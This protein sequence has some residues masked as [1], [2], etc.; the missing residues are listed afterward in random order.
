MNTETILAILKNL[1]TRDKNKCIQAIQKLYRDKTSK[2]ET[3]NDELNE[4]LSKHG[5]LIEE[6]YEIIH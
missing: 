2:V 3:K 4:W 5:F 6:E 1:S